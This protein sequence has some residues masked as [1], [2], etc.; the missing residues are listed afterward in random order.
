MG[1]GLVERENAGVGRMAKCDAAHGASIWNI[2]AVALIINGYYA[3]WMQWSLAW[4]P[5]NEETFETLQRS[6]VGGVHPEC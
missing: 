6:R 3:G 4:N 1:F 5:L 2:R